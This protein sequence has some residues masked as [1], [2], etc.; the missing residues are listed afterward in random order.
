MALERDL[1]QEQD[2]LPEAAAR[3]ALRSRRRA[4]LALLVVA[5]IIVFP[6]YFY[7]LKAGA[8]IIG[9]LLATPLGTMELSGGV[10]VAGVL[11]VLAGR[12]LAKRL[13]SVEKYEE[14]HLEGAGQASS[15]EGVQILLLKLF[16]FLGWKLF[17]CGVIGVMVAFYWMIF[18]I[19]RWAC[20]LATPCFAALMFTVELR[21]NHLLLKTQQ[22]VTKLLY[23]LAFGQAGLVA[24][25]FYA[26][27][28]IAWWACLPV[29]GVL[30]ISG[31]FTPPTLNQLLRPVVAS[32]FGR[33]NSQT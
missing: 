10:G 32:W 25:F 22:R 26:M 5:I 8:R 31:Y 4:I 11:L 1:V 33:G 19:G 28:R 16:R 3:S 23:L 24:A 12:W 29:L 17:V 27:F 9:D 2:A 13:R 6:I 30:V 15:A 21:I 14:R 7:P 20:L 18:S